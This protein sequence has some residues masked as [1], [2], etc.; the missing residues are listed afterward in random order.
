MT[1]GGVIHGSK[2]CWFE[3]H[4]AGRVHRSSGI[5]VRQAMV[6]RFTHATPETDGIG[7]GRLAYAASQAD[8]R[9]K[10]SG[11]RFTHATPETDGIDSGRLAYAASQA[12]GLE[13]ASG[14]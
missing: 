1:P 7:S 14:L 8:G 5:S 10:P 6:G 4:S 9:R 11:R 13:R 12:D 3:F 2:A